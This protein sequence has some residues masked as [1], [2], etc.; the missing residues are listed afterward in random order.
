MS[1][2]TFRSVAWTSIERFGTQVFQAIFT[3]AL[4]RMLMPEDYGL[5]AMVFIFLMAGWMLMDGGLPLAL[6]QKKNPTEN[7]FSTVFWFNVLFGLVLYGV[8]FW[9]APFIA[10]FYEQP[11]L[12]PIIK[13]VG[14]NV[15]IWSFGAVHGAK[16]DIALKFKK[17]A[18]IGMSAMLISGLFGVGLAYYGYGVWAL[19][20][21]FLTNHSLRIA[22][23]WIFG[24]RWRPR[25]IFSLTSLKSL[26]SFGFA[27]TLSALLDT[28]YKNIYA[29]FIGRR[30]TVGEL[31]LFQQG[32]NLSN[33]LTTNI[34]YTIA[35]SFIPLQSTFHDN[36]DKQHYLFY[37]FLSL[38]C[39]II[40]PLAI[41]LAVLAEPFVSFVLTKKWLQ[42]VP[43]LQ[44]LCLS[45]LWYPVLVTNERMLLA[46][47]FS[48]PY[49]MSQIIKK[50]FGFTVFFMCLPHGI[51][52]ICA[53]IGFYAFF[54]MVVS[55][56]FL[57]KYLSIRWIE[58]LKIVLP[59]LGLAVFSGIVAWL[60]VLGTTYYA[61][62]SDF[63]KL[64]CGGI[65]GLGV[66]A[67][68]A[69]LLKLDEW[70]FMLNYLKNRHA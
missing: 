44:I 57:Q 30:Y 22:C 55:V 43:F 6:V 3:I 19:V 34:A 63:M 2:T 8:F 59:V 49:L 28:I 58:Q 38:A 64:V 56:I 70:K 18:F 52:W 4:A 16:L 27:V 68:G 33:L 67:I 51:F 14:L 10:R 31:G 40:F 20:F 26:F 23:Y 50:A 46:K 17:Q 1:N 41:L 5:I 36:P 61:S 53:S 37:R 54:D 62:A 11:A 48:R 69:H 66:Y 32:Y 65:S 60:V 9:S 35:R 39:F 12:I 42:A 7:D 45:Y 24:E 29:V 21:Q 25:L 47:G 15:V 13:V